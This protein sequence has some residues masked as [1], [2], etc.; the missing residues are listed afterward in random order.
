[1]WQHCYVHFL[2]NALEEMLW[3]IF[4]EEQTMTASKNF[5]GFMLAEI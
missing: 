1:M 5:A 2:R 4:L 3:I